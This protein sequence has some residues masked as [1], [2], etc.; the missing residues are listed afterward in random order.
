MTKP[1]ERTF[2]L[3]LRGLHAQAGATFR[4]RWGWSLP[5]RYSDPAEEYA[6]L[7]ERAVVIDRSQRSRFL[8]TGTDAAVVLGRLFSGYVEELEEARALRVVALN[9]HGAIRD[10]AVVART[11]AIAYLV[12]GEPGQREETHARLQSAVEADFDVHIEDRTE[13]T[14]LLELAGPAAEPA[15][16]ANL[17]EGLPA[18]LQALH[19]AAFEFH[20]FRS[21]AIRT[22]DTGE[23]GFGFM[24][25]PAVAQHVIETL[26]AG[27]VRLCG[28]EAAES[29]RVEGCIPAFDPDLVPGLSPA[30]ADL[31]VLLGIPGGAE[32]RIL[33]ALL[34]EGANVVPS[35]T[36]IAIDG[37]AIG[38]LGSCVHSYGLNATIALGIIDTREALPGRQ[39]DLSGA[40]AL[41]GTKASA[42]AKPFLRRRTH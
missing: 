37:R 38:T 22:S 8:V 1:D 30:E 16:R 19:C 34:V 31:D 20:G 21:L 11:G 40:K 2:H 15:A 29:A 17:S 42:V 23:D 36:A 41:S 39:F 32:G 12:I 25:A 4:T 3:A 7:R 28:Y 24:L 9:E 18:R 35:G 10:V 26:T 5:E 27:G 13:T 14:C 33:S 6:A